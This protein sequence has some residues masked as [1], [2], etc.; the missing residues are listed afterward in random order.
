[1]NIREPATAAAFTPPVAALGVAP[2]LAA[3]ALLEAAL[4]VACA[5]LVA[6]RP[7]LL[8]PD[9]IEPQTDSA[10]VASAIVRQARALR[11]NVNEYRVALILE[12]HPDGPIP[13]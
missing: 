3:L 1:V 4:E 12:P 2:E 8:R 11:A 5:A 13:F 10:R 9:D 6:A 7:E